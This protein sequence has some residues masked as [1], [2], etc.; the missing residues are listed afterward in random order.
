MKPE[1]LLIEPMMAAIEKQLD[2]RYQVHRL[3]EASDERAFSAYLQSGSWR[4]AHSA[5]SRPDRRARAAPG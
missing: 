3:F 2:E 1:L 4:L 5:R